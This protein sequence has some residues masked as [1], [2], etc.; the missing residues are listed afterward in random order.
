MRKSDYRKLGGIVILLVLWWLLAYAL[1][2]H[3]L[4]PSP[5]AVGKVMLC[6][7]QNTAFYQAIIMTL[8]RCVIGFVISYGTA[9][10]LALVTGH[11]KWLRDYLAP[12]IT[13][14]KSVPNISFILLIM[15][16]FN[17]EISVMIIVF[18]VLFPSFYSSFTNGFDAIDQSLREVMI[19]Y[20]QSLWRQIVKV[21][22]PLLKPYL[23]ASYESGIG[24]AFKVGVMAEILGQVPD[25]IG[26]KLQ[27]SYLNIEMAEVFAWTI[28]LIILLVLLE[29]GLRLLWKK[30]KE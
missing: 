27:W 16:W 20:P 28:W 11:M 25:G 10:V 22:L 4:F 2:R 8:S 19:L 23:A 7:L 5:F 13:L 1:N 15:I 12:L 14:L 29:H 9:L 3:F 18:F 24:L 6:Q 30:R 21:E 26:K 17:R